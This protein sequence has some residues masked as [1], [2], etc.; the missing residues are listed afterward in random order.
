MTLRLR[1]VSDQR[2]SLGDRSS[3]V[4]TAD[5]G[6]IGRS[7]DNDW[8]LPDPLRYVSAHHAR[9][10]FRNGRFYLQDVSTNGV[11]VNDEPDPISRRAPEGYEIHNGDMI[12]VG[13]YQ[14][15]AALDAEIE[16]PQ[17]DPHF[18]TG[19]AAVPTSIHALH[20]LG[21][22]SQTDIGAMLNLDDLLI[23][24]SPTGEEMLPVN[25]YGQAIVQAA[26]APRAAPAAAARPAPNTE[27]DEDS[28]A[29]RVERLARA[30]KR[31]LKNGANSSN[32]ANGPG[33][34]D[35]SAGLQ[36]FCRGAGID[37]DRLPAE[38]QTRLLHLAGQ[39]F[40][41][42]LVGFKDLERNRTESR[43]RFR[44][45]LPP[46]DADDPRP[47]LSR[48]TVEEL[49][50]RLLLQHEQRSLDSV[51]WLREAVNE[52]KI[53]ELATAQATRAAFVEFLDRLDPAEL[54]ARFERAARRG[55]ARSADKAQ[56]WDLF[57]T[58]YRN[59]I[60]MPADHLPHT[61]VEAFAAAYREYLKKAAEKI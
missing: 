25:A 50:M 30:A 27:P 2:R 49:L 41:E 37:A 59:L 51:Q 4:L 8:V 57:T 34:F 35:V 1:V 53:H 47:S 48:A 10:Q 18:D 16:Q 54:E 42:A 61:F 20:T 33:L 45:E 43:N 9:V 36:V 52:A 58:F 14:I 23:P 26:P 19:A 22:A 39:L 32:A 13:D 5:G 31:D 17:A 38:A 7:A 21:R 3:I 46:P 28:I 60:E 44:I 29:R 55:K 24:D 56:Y 15:V 6:T 40:R 11:F 12:R